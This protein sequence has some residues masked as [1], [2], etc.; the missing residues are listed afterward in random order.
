MDFVTSVLKRSRQ[1]TMKGSNQAKKVGVEESMDS[2]SKPENHQETKR[3]IRPLGK[4]TSKWVIEP[5]I[6]MSIN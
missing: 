5:L 1:L 3:V 2:T 4:L 6:V